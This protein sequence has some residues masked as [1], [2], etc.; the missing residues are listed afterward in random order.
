MVSNDG[1]V[2]IYLI[3]YFLDVRFCFVC[4]CVCVCVCVVCLCMWCGVLYPFYL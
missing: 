4:V 1:K 2:V 3:L